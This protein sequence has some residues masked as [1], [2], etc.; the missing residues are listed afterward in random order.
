MS[1]YIIDTS[2]ILKWFNQKNEERINIAK[3]IYDDMIDGKITIIIPTLLQIELINVLLTAKK[4]P[5]AEIKKILNDLILLPLIIKEPTQKVFEETLDIMKLFSLAAY[6][7]LFL[8]MAKQEK[9]KLISDDRKGHGKIM[10][11]SVIMLKDY[12]VS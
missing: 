3:Q 1:T 9:C 12:A 7:A 10:D 6:D 11:G 4:L 2:V 8:A 5:S